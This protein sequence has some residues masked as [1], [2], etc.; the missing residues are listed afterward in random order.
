MKK[1]PDKQAIRRQTEKT[2]P[3]DGRIWTG[4][5]DSPFMAF[6]PQLSSRISQ[7]FRPVLFETVQIWLVPKI[8]PN[9]IR[10]FERRQMGVC[11]SKCVKKNKNAEQFTFTAPKTCK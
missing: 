10:H 2:P 6:S 11:N 7:Q 9:S 4:K 5:Q 8:N 1:Y 3:K